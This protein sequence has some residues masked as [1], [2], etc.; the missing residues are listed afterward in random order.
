MKKQQAAAATPAALGEAYRRT[1]SQPRARARVERILEVAT[2]LIAKEGTD[3]LRMSEVA[4]HAEVSIG[5]LYQYFPDKAAIVR[6][7]AERYNA[8]GRACVAAEL[9]GVRSAADVR[10]A[11][12]RITDGYYAM[13]LAEPAMRDIW[14][15][16]QSDKALQDLDAE[17]CRAHGAALDA[18][19]ARARPSM[20]RDE[21]K[22]LGFLFMQ[23]LNTAVRLAVTVD[24]AE[25]D[26][27]IVAFK[28]AVLAK[29]LVA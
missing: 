14:S 3:R 19:L 17:D 20:A 28:Q 12:M 23:L 2:T 25:G 6:T 26:A 4:E 5:S 11:L 18:A 29:F 27:L 10:N 15:G 9:A 16:M 7:L 1:P 8:E 13:F 24:R 21:R 22:A